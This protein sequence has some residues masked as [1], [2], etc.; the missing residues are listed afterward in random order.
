MIE[1]F[2]GV[3][4]DQDNFIEAT[5]K[6]NTLENR[7]DQA[8]EKVSNL[9]VE[10]IKA[11]AKEKSALFQMKGLKKKE[12]DLDSHVKKLKSKLNDLERA[13]LD[14]KN[15]FKLPMSVKANDIEVNKT[16]GTDF[17]GFEERIKNSFENRM[18]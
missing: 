5:G 10:L 13:P 4:L 15:Q 14:R 12:K 16:V 11:G 2:Y 17:S 18:G 8:L 7:L 9:Q 3:S 1:N 6:I